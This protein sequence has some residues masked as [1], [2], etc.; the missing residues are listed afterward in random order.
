MEDGV[1]G[2]RPEAGKPDR[3]LWQESRKETR[4]E[5]DGSS[6]HTRSFKGWNIRKEKRLFSRTSLVAWGNF[7]KTVQNHITFIIL[8][9]DVVAPEKWCWL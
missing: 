8:H 2:V 3:K 9:G 4:V 1:Q 5:P 6:L 7:R